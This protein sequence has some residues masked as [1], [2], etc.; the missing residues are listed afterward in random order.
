MQLRRAAL[1]AG[2]GL[3]GLAVTA[4]ATTVKPNDSDSASCT[5]TCTGELTL[6]ASDGSSEFSLTILGDD[7]TNLQIGC[8]DNI[9]AGGS[10]D[11][12][13]EC[14]SGGVYL[15]R[16]G[17]PFPETLTVAAAVGTNFGDQQDLTPDYTEESACGSTC[18]SASATFEMPQ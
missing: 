3:V 5:E 2:L 16:E 18:N 9:R 4:C 12:T 8:P 17:A 14:I 15:E 11:V 1:A 10:S 6:S 7:F 13:A